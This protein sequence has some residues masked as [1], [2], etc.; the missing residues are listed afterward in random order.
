LIQLKKGVYWVG[1][2][3]WDIK[4]FHGYVT[5]RGTSYNSYLLVSDK[6]ALVDTVK[7]PFYETML[8]HVKEVIEPDKI[9]YIIANHGEP[10][11]SGSLV[12]IS[13]AAPDAE[14]VAT[15]RG[16]NILT[17]YYGPLEI[18][19]TKEKPELDLGGKTLHFVPVPMAH[20]PDSMVTYI[21]ED[22]LLLSNDAFGQ[23][24]ASTGRF[25]DEV[26][27]DV[28]MHETTAYYANIL[29]PLNSSV[30][31]A[32][33]ALEGTPIEMIAPSHGVIWRSNLEDILK[34]YVGWVEGRTQ[35]KVVIAYDSMWHSTE[36]MTHAI[37]EG[38]TSTGTELKVFNL[39]QN[40]RSDAITE[41]LDCKAILIGSP[42]LNNTVFPT[43]AAFLAYLRGLR[44]ANKIG[45]AYGSFGWGGGAK[46]YVEKELKDTGVELID[47]DLEFGF[48]PTDEE[49]RKCYE[50]GRMIGE[51]V[52]Q[53]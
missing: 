25:D 23:H 45:A 15:E 1:A 32:L 6:V 53:S 3:D 39:T 43:V 40:H 29:M 12:K 46:K 49:W 41:I 34:K 21:P 27:K 48:R 2:V 4:N 52:K 38:I 9:D 8:R 16:K 42:T 18:T 35:P 28:L 26:D 36:I 50:F 44:P 51:R 47:N 19:T 7:A 13:E 37:A 17:K 24:L 30:G 5:H 22:R 31:R 14:I 20:W 10:D 11:H 33:K